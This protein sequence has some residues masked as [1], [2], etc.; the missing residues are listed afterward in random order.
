MSILLK[1]RKAFREY[2]DHA[3][4]NMPYVRYLYL[5]E[6]EYNELRGTK[7]FLNYNIRHDGKDRF[8]GMEVIQVK[9]K[10]HISFGGV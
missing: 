9:C 6:E 2:R 8:E 4:V 3:N 1:I 5:G 7:Q 10:N